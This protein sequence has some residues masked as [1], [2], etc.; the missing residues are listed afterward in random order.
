MV[1]AACLPPNP[2]ARW[3]PRFPTV[4]A[5]FIHSSSTPSRLGSPP[6]KQ[7]AKVAT[8]HISR[9]HF[10]RARIWW[11]FFFQVRPLS[12]LSRQSTFPHSNSLSSKTFELTTF[13][14]SATYAA[15]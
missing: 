10:L 7:I 14:N 4:G 15:I 12:A 6:A 13:P 5:F 2:I 1:C 3:Q 8:Y 11:L 9:S